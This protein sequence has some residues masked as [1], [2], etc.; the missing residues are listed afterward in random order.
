[1]GLITPRFDEDTLAKYPFLQDTR[2]YLQELRYDILEL[3]KPES[4]RIVARARKRIIE[5]IKDAEVSKELLDKEIEIPSFHL[6]LL[7]V[8]W[9]GLE[10]LM[11]RY[12]FAEAIRA[13]E[14]LKSEKAEIGRI[15]W[16]V[17]KVEPLPVKESPYKFRIGVKEYLDRSTSFHT[18]N[19]KLVNRKLEHGYVYVKDYELI[20]LIREEVMY[21]IHS[22]LHSLPSIKL[23]EQF[24]PIVEEIVH[25]T[26]PPV[27]NT[28]EIMVTP[29][30][31]PPCLVH[32]LEL[33]QTGQN[34]PHYGRFLMATYLLRI[35]K[36]VNEI[37]QLYQK[38]P[39]FNEKITRYQ[40]EHIAGLRGGKEK[41]SVP[42]CKTL[43]THNFCFRTEACGTIIN[44]LQFGRQKPQQRKKRKIAR[45][46]ATPA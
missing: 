46:N 38:A 10:H 17:T 1:M 5:S 43:A 40:V 19:W 34:V 22:R 36:S 33:L 35:G 31:Y 32:A 3:A 14:I 42:S 21:L 9:A 15:F 41:Y 16:K 37:V 12:S 11:T 4:N 2:D 20:R 44:P 6:A 26:P 29:D 18:P 27:D 25:M 8:K 13:E 23:P 28:E 24:Q 30:K 39:D 7:F 45:K